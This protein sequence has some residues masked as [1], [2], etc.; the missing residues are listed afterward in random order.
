MHTSSWDKMAPLYAKSRFCQCR[1]HLGSRQKTDALAVEGEASGY[2]LIAF[3]VKPCTKRS[4]TA[5]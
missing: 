5:M 3:L 4:C 2:S 1:P